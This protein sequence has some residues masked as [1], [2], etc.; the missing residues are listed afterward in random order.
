M[1]VGDLV[2]R[3][4]N[5]IKFNPSTPGVDIKHLKEEIGI[6]IDLPEKTVYKPSIGVMWSTLGIMNEHPDDIEVINESQ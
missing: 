4:D 5:W 2:R 1:K 6:V 3:I